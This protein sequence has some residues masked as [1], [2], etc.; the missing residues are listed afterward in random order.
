MPKV[1]IWLTSYNHGELLRESIESAL[2]Q[3]YQDYELV[4]VDDCST[5]NS[6][7]IIREYA[8]RDPR[9]RTVFHEKNIGHSGLKEELDNFAGEYVAILCGD[10]KWEED[11]LE[12]QIK[13]LEQHEN[14]VACFT[15]VQAIDLD[16]KVYTGGQVGANAFRAENRSRY[17]WLRYFFYHNNCL[18]HPSLLIRKSAYKD[19]EILKVGFLT[20]LPD[21]YEWV[22]LCFHAD[23]YVIPE[24]LTLFRVHEDETNQSGETAGKLN[25]V[26]FE[27]YFIYQ[28]Y[29]CIQ[30]VQTL[31]KIFPESQQ[32]IQHGDCVVEFALAKMFLGGPR[33]SQ[34]LLGLNMLSDLMQGEETKRKLEE[35]YGY[36]EQEFNLEKQKYDIF[37]AAGRERFLQASL[38]VN[39]GNGYNEDECIREKAFIPAT[40]TARI[41]FDIEGAFPGKKIVGLR[42]DPDEEIYRSYSVIKA[43]WENGEDAEIR[44]A[45]GIR[46]DGLDRFY[47]LDPQ[48]EIAPGEHQELQLILKV[49]PLSTADVERERE[50]VKSKAR[51]LEQKLKESR[52]EAERYRCM[53]REHKRLLEEYRSSLTIRALHKLRKEIRKR[54]R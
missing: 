7:D 16:G 38:Y 15:D 46:E 4:I 8:Q 2:H 17:E 31:I 40:Q 44:P 23:I 3:T 5:D 20:S 18:C 11:K 48:Y 43:Q 41:V 29:F 42:F 45:N 34:K 37:G 22:K 51:E 49:G 21:F 9:I 24:K 39:T 6:R 30:D 14:I 27:E 25:R 36:G 10:D 50:A 12:K 13:V 32:Y 53:Y 26:F 33:R 52:E 54:K 35:L 47:T 1:S 19:Y 28:T